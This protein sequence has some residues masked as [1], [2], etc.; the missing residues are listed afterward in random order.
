MELDLEWKCFLIP[1]GTCTRK[2]FHTAHDTNKIFLW[3]NSKGFWFGRIACK[4]KYDH[5][6]ALN[7][8]RCEEEA[9]NKV[10]QY[11]IN[12]LNKGIKNVCKTI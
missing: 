4:R 11:Y 2:E 12:L 7:N 1:R 5:L 10:T 3:K 8:I 6:V 9:K